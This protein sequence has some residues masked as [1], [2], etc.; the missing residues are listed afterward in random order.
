MAGFYQATLSRGDAS[1]LNLENEPK[2][3]TLTIEPVHMGYKP[4]LNYDNVEGLLEYS[5]GD[6]HR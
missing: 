1:M 3:R 5:E 4:G 6:Q 2:R